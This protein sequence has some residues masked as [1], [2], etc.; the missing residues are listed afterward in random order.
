MAGQK[1]EDAFV[2]RLEH[3]VNE[4]KKNREWRRGY[5]TLLMRDI[6]NFEKG[7]EIGGESL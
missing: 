7:K 2:H 1:P 5:M 6:E 3:A 4:A